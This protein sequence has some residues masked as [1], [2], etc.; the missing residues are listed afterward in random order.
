MSH[1]KLRQSMENLQKAIRRLE[2]ALNEDEI[3]SLYIDGTI[4]RFEFTFELYWKTLK[5]LLEEE[6]I[7]PKTPRDTLKRAYAIGWLENE[8][9]W[10]QMLRDRNETSYVYDE[11]KAK[12][13]YKHIAGYFPEMKATF[14]VLKEKYKDSE[15]EVPND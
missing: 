5:R 14:N 9:S 6:G 13:I 8:E 2:D 15:N 12:R 10:L 4:Q 11:E 3:N 1:R 7:E